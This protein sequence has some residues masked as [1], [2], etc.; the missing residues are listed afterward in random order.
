MTRIQPVQPS[1]AGPL[2]RV[3][4]R[5]AR[6]KTGQLAGR[7]T[8]KMIEPLE[9]FAHSPRLLLG[10]GMME[11]ANEKARRVEHRLKELAQLKAATLSHCE[12]C[13]DIGSSIARRSGLSD[14]QLL[15]LPCYRDSALFSDLEKLVLDYASG[16]SVT[17]VDVSDELFAA[18]REHFDEAQL[19]ELTSVIALENFRGRFNLALGIGAA[20]FSEGMVCAVPET[21]PTSN[22]ERAQTVTRARAG[23]PEPATVARGG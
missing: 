10:Y 18:L 16:I 4:L 1:E 20:G 5:T 6:R 2:T 7:H 9:V 13:I 23:G 14:E 21:R 8:D 11:L 19:V 12:Y 22:G 15:A 3:V 17:P